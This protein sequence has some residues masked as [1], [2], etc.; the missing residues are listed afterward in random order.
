M[1]SLGAHDAKNGIHAKL[2]NIHAKVAST[3]AEAGSI[4]AKIGSMP[5]LGTVLLYGGC[6]F[7]WPRNSDKHF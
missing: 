1:L 2:G 5:C 3:H 4:H 7:P 6:V